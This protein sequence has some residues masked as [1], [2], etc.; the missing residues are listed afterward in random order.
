M[1]VEQ[2]DIFGASEF[3]VDCVER[4]VVSPGVLRLTFGT[5]ER[6][7]CV[8]KVKLLISADVMRAELA[9]AA[10]FLNGSASSVQ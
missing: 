3:W 2:V 6:G 9:R 1:D 5:H 10:K 8:T 4:E 7:A